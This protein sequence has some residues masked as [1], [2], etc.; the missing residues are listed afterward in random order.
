[1]YEFNYDCIWLQLSR[2]SR[3]YECLSEIIRKAAW[4]L[5]L[6]QCFV[7]APVIIAKKVLLTNPFDSPFYELLTLL[8]FASFIDFLPL[9]SLQLHTGRKRGCK[10][11]SPVRFSSFKSRY[12]KWHFIPWNPGSTRQRLENGDLKRNQ[13][14]RI[15][16]QHP[17]FLRKMLS[18]LH[19]EYY[20]FVSS[21]FPFVGECFFIHGKY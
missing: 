5:T 11:I 10:R 14:W 20:W 4:K 19:V 21:D 13:I 18:T 9:L 16:K 3:I 7:F 1:M 6:S 17:S 15:S 12:M 2:T 8:I